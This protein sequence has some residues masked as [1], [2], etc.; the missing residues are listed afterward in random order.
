MTRRF[1]IVGNGAAGLAAAEAIRRL[2]AQAEITI[3]G[4]EPHP[5][6]SRPGL[7][8][9]LSG[10]LPEA[11]LFSRPEREYR[12]L[13]IRRLTAK[14]TLIKAEAHRLELENGESL[15]Y[16]ALLLAVGARAVRPR[17]PG[18]D[19]DGVVVLDTLDD[20]RDIINRSRRAKRA[21]VVGGGIT[22]MEIAEGLAARGVETHYL[23]RRDRYWANVLDSDESELVEDRLEEEGV[24]LHHNSE[25]ARILGRG[26]RVTGVELS[27][28]HV[29]SC[30][31]VGVAIGIAPRVDLAR[32]SGLKVSRGIAVDPFLRTSA[33]DVF[34]AGDVAE[35]FDPDIG[36][37]VL[38][39]LWWLAIEQ[40]KAAGVNMAGRPRAYRKGIPF[41]VTRV[42]G[43]TTTIL[44]CVGQRVEDEDLVAIARG[45]S[46]TWRGRPDA[47]EVEDDSQRNRVRVLVG[48]E[49]IM[50]ALLMGD[51]SLSLPLQDLIRERVDVTPVRDHLLSPERH[52]SS[53]ITNYWETWRRGQHVG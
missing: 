53:V 3:V 42:G 5:F 41:N 2:D 39:S 7:A 4:D 18:I 1:V 14:A 35:V 52:L 27:P 17:T 37:P 9:Y 34:A 20:A 50:G 48:R 13:G 30:Q 25:I 40:G 10:L 23:L 15:A 45:D 6:Y 36:E 47:S 21:V 31:I 11:Q 16:D 24:R 49:R 38:D 26:G 43:V 32:A 22:A 8:Y 33:P 51:Q 19:L 12:Q 44:G 29:L 28:G 46:Q